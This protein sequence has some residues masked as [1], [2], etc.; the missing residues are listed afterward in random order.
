M[1]DHAGSVAKQARKLAPFAPLKD[2][3]QLPDLGQPWRDQ[4]RGIL[5]A[6]VDVDEVRAR[7][8]AKVDDDVDDLYHAIFDDLLELMRTDPVNVDRGH[9]DPVRGPLP[10]AGRRP[11]DEHRRG[12]RV[13]RLGR[14]GG[15]QPLTVALH[16]RRGVCKDGDATEDR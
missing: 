15:P 11:R 9:A 13:P 14:G 8:V 3:V 6:L 2:Y 10:R 7:E 12:H 16:S 1:G 5:R 4:V